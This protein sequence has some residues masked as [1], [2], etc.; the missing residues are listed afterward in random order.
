VNFRGRQKRQ[1]PDAP[2]ECGAAVPCLAAF[3]HSDLH[4]QRLPPPIHSTESVYKIIR[5]PNKSGLPDL[6]AFPRSVQ[7]ASVSH[8]WPEQRL[9]PAAREGVRSNYRGTL[10]DPFQKHGDQLVLWM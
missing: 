9:P 4:R 2:G 3:A 5:Q 6:R 7:N 1:L 10:Q 8:R